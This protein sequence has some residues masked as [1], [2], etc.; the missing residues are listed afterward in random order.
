MR[1]KSPNGGHARLRPGVATTHA[2]V[3]E[4]DFGDDTCEG[5]LI[6]RL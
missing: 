5:R 2:Q 1:P 4:D 6:V 3:C